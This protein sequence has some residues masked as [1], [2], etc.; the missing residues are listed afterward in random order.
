LINFKEGSAIDDLYQVVIKN[1][2]DLTLVDIDRAFK[3]GVSSVVHSIY[4]WCDE[5]SKEQVQP[6]PEQIKSA[7]SDWISYDVEI[8]MLFNT[9]LRN[10]RNEH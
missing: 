2:D 10:Q 4:E 1:H 3:L 8:N 5:I 7:F 9:L 6:T